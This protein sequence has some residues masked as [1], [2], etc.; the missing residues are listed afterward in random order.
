VTGSGTGPAPKLSPPPFLLAQAIFESNLFPYKY[1]SILKPSHSS[2]L[3][4]YEN[5]TECSEKS[6]YKI[7]TPGNYL[8]KN[9][10]HAE[11]GESLKLRLNASTLQNS[12]THTLQSTLKQPQYKIH[13]K[14]IVPTQSSTLNIRSP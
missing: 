7:Q 13:T 6:A 9:I 14:K 4:A 3:S 12:H 8:E 10:Q 1:S 2:Y 5:G 11:Q